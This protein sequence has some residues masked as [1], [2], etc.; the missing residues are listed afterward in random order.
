MLMGFTFLW[1]AL[2]SVACT[3]APSGGRVRLEGLDN[4]LLPMTP[5][6]SALWLRSNAP[7][8]GPLESS[9]NF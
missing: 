9:L 6:L 4:V 8:L 2:W 5:R 7:V 1:D 3:T